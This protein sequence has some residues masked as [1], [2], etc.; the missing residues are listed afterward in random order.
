[1]YKISDEDDHQTYF[2]EH[3]TKIYKIHFKNGR[4]VDFIRLDP[5]EIRRLVVQTQQAVSA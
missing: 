1:M 4:L 3:K 2:C 5:A